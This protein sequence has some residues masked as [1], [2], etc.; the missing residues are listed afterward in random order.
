MDQNQAKTSSQLYEM[1]LYGMIEKSY[2]NKLKTRLC[3]ICG[4]STR[5]DATNSFAT[6]EIVFKTMSTPHTKTETETVK[7]KT[8]STTKAAELNTAGISASHLQPI[9]EQVNLLAVADLKISKASKTFDSREWKYIKYL[10]REQQSTKDRTFKVATRNVSYSKVFSDNIL[11]FLQSMEITYEYEYIKKG[12]QYVTPTGV[13]ISIYQLYSMDH[14][15]GWNQPDHV[16]NVDE[17]NYLVEV[18]C[19]SNFDNIKDVEPEMLRIADNV[20]R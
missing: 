15:H 14:T 7:S 13:C 17:D 10:G 2:I 12:F 6:W 3:G 18:S 20:S 5:T 9:P 11:E 8:K 16:K 1:T 4:T 19:S